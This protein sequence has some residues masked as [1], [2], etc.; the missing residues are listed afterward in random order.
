[1]AGAGGGGL[2]PAPA[3]RELPRAHIG[4]WRTRAV[5]GGRSGARTT[6][7]KR[8]GTFG[9]RGGLGCASWKL[10]LL[11]FTRWKRVG[12]FGCGEG[13]WYCG[14]LV[15]FV[16]GFL[17]ENLFEDLGHVFDGIEDPPGDINGSLILDCN[18]D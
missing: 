17:G 6:R 11:F 15:V 5:F 3:L 2:A 14:G 9:A 10:P 4:Q 1:M 8:V 13:R 16:L 18:D 12:T 7:W